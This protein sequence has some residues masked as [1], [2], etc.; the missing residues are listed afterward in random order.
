MPGKVLIAHADQKTAGRLENDLVREGCTTLSASDLEQVRPL[1]HQQ[2]DL[3]LL[4]TKLA[5]TASAEQL[6]ALGT[7]LELVGTLCLRLCREDI[8]FGQARTLAPWACGTITSPDASEQ[9][10]EQIGTLLRVK[11]AEKER[12]LA[13]GRLLLYQR[14][15]AE[16]LR[17]AAHIQRTLLP[18]RYPNCEAF[19]FAWQFLPCETVGGDLFNVHSLADNTLM[20][21]MLDVSGHG[22]S[23]AMVTVSVNQS[24]SDRTSHLVKQPIDQPPFF[25]I[26]TPAEVITALDREYPYERFEKFFTISYL[27]LEPESGRV[28]YCNGGHPPPILVRQDGRLELLEAG[29]TLVGLGGLLP[30][31]EGEVLLQ[32]GDRLYLYSDGIT[33]YAAPSGEMYGGRRLNDFLCRQQ[34]TSLEEVASS[35]IE[36]LK[37]FGEGL[38][39][40]DDIS[41]FCIQFNNPAKSRRACER[42][43]KPDRKNPC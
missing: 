6:S 3:L 11:Q 36:T 24:L 28:R 18:N 2:P 30:Y 43:A 7:E 9:I 19:S 31:E 34:L 25:R 40:D 38:A 39:P 42:E 29:G 8:D 22:V 13:Q 1:L 5:S 35:F 27:L 32:P 20:A 14:E 23:S 41:L 17:S 16:G 10:L 21:Y 4:D 33:E 12:N 26:A 15:V 37:S